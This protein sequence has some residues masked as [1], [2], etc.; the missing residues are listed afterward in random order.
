[1]TSERTNW[2]IA[3]SAVLFFGAY[4]GAYYA[5]VRAVGSTLEPAPWPEYK[6]VGEVGTLIFWPA[7]CIDKVF[8]P[9]EWERAW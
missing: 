2:T 5:L 9:K 1:M 6:Y 3:F 7:H 8:R 4:M